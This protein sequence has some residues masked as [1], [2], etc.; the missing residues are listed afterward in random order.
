MYFDIFV[1]GM[2]RATVGHEALENLS[3]SV[4]GSPDGTFLFSGAVC[5]ENGETY[6]IDWLNDELKKTDE[7]LIKPSTNI[8]ADAPIKRFKMKPSNERLSSEKFCDF[9]KRPG[10]EVG[11]LIMTG[12]TPAICKHCIELCVDIMTENEK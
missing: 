7:I 1:N 11:K 8:E 10:I 12:S 4:S 2:K 6:H 5:N 9:C 3:I